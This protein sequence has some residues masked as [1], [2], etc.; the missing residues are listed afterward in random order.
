MMARTCQATPVAGNCRNSFPVRVTYSRY[1]QSLK[2]NRNL[3][4]CGGNPIPIFDECIAGTSSLSLMGDQTR[5]RFFHFCSTETRTLY[6]L[7]CSP[8]HVTDA[9][10]LC[11]LPRDVE[12][13]DWRPD[14]WAP[15]AVKHS[16]SRRVAA[17]GVSVTVFWTA[18]ILFSANSTSRASTF[19]FRLPAGNLPEASR[20]PA[21]IPV[22]ISMPSSMVCTA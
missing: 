15:V 5:L 22:R 11:G 10:N 8:C 1:P 2:D 6:C 16:K 18:I 3:L 12:E 20:S 21:G 17:H 13:C 7:H 14:R 19:W 4:F 9:Q